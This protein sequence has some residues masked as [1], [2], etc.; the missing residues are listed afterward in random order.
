MRIL[1]IETSCDE[2]AVSILEATGTPE[3][4]V[5]TVL[6]NA[7][8]SQA[9]EHARYGGVYP[10]L[11]KREHAKNIVPLLVSALK[12]A[13]LF[14]GEQRSLPE[15]VTDSLRDIFSHEEGLAE[16]FERFAALCKPPNIDAIAVT[17]GPGLAPALWVGVNVAQALARVWDMPLIPINHLDGHMVASMVTATTDGEHSYK[18]TDVQFPVLGLIISGGHSEFVLS[19]SLG[20]YRVIGS[21]RDDSVGE[22]FDKVAR[23]LSLPYPGGPAVSQ[24]ATQGRALRSSTDQA[25]PALQSLPRP[26]LH[27]HDLDLSFSGLKT[28]VLYRTRDL[29][30]MSDHARALTAAEFE[31][32]ITDVLVSKTERALD[33]F[34]APTVCVGGGVS[35]NTFLRARLE[36]QLSQTHP[37]TMLAFPASGLSTD[38]AIMIGMAAYLRHARGIPDLDP[39]TELKAESNLSLDDASS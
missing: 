6:G 32:A 33:Q 7:L 23:M 31:D 8:Y 5:F 14:T 36:Q 21:T 28:A 16:V 34:P 22:S 1:A 9:D 30:D 18:M 17:Y 4:A 10:T 12:E 38:N 39:R 19:E 2:T 26:M 3:S 20:S 25:D 37:D 24:L 35:A 13:G 11:A 27:S 15:S 29:G